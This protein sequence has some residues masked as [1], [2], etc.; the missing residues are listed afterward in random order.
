[1]ID[2]TTDVGL[3][4][5]IWA[6]IC[7]R[8]R[9]TIFNSYWQIYALCISIGIMYDEQLEFESSED[10]KTVPR[11]VLN[12]PNNNSLLD[13]L[14]QSA[15]LTSLKTELSEE[16]RLELAFAEKSKIDFNKLS[17]LTSFA[18]FGATKLHEL[19]ENKEDIEIMEAIMSFLNDAFENGVMP[20]IDIDIQ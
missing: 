4:G 7:D 13:F 2:A 18:N 19:I 15:I 11:T 16:Q 9:D 20:A 12:H 8:L 3:K 1:M 10:V 14:F 5:E 6:N 17:F